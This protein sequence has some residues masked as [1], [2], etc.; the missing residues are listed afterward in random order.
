MNPN[1]PIYILSKG[2]WESRLTSKAL[3]KRNIP[4][5]IVVEPNEYEFYASVIDK[6]KV[7][8]LPENFSERGEGS[9]PTRNW[10]WEHSIQEGFERHWLLD[11]NISNF[12]RLNR[13]RKLP[14]GDGTIFRCVEDF[15]N[16]YENVAF[17]GFNNIAFAPDRSPT[18]PPFYLN[19]RVYSMTLI[20]NDLPYRWRGKYNE[21]T[22]ICIRALKDGWCTILFNAF[23]GDKATT[24]TMKGGNT[25][26][27]YNTGDM[28]REFAES[29][30]AQ[31]PD[32]VEVVWKFNRWHHQVDYSKFKK[33]KLIKKPTIEVKEGVNDYGMILTRV[34]PVE[35]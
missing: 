7:L 12:L 8:A 33:N 17:S 27:I 18:I 22:D 19:T 28:R 16:R 26:T 20:K 2:R 1:Y 30:K 4:Y 13:N 32:I 29:L 34:T 24:M 5:R 6:N 31:H 11:D 35:A 15:T 10:I 21:D 23:L 9:I 14:V 25:D 3:E